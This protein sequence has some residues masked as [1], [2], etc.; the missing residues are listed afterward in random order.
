MAVVEQPELVLLGCALI[1]A[2]IVLGVEL[3]ELASDGLRL[4]PPSGPPSS[5]ILLSLSDCNSTKSL[6][7]LTSDAEDAP[8]DGQP[9]LPE[10]P[11]SLP[12]RSLLVTWR[13]RALRRT[14]TS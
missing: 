14:P 5:V 2:S 3:T 1:L 13:W 9:W 12:Q 11:A 7:T 8:L 4:S 6:L 10:S